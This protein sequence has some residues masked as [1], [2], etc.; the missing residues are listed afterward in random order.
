TRVVSDWSSDVCSSDLGHDVLDDAV[1]ASGVHAL[2]HD[3]HGPAAVGVKA[4]LHFGKLADA[5][6][7]D[8]LRL[9]GLGG[10]A[11]RLGGIVIGEPETP[12]L[13]DPAGFDD[14]GKLHCRLLE[15]SRGAR[16]CT[17][18]MDVFQPS[19]LIFSLSPLRTPC[20]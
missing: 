13:V 5:V 11:E 1:L 17:Q 15:F 14:L 4:L 19:S 20:A 3:K 2:E 12:G 16:I 18:P 9:G 8:E 10:K 6:G 7:K